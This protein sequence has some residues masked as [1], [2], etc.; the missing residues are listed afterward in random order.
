MTAAAGAEPDR[1]EREPQI[2][3]HEQVRAGEANDLVVRLA[4]VA[5]GGGRG[6]IAFDLAADEESVELA[7]RLHAPGFE[8][9][10]DPVAPMTVHRARDPQT[11]RVRF[12]LTARDPGEQPVRREVSAEFWLGN[13]LIGAVTHSTFVV[14]PDQEGGPADGRTVTRGF[15]LPREKREDADLIVYIVADE[16]GGEARY[17]VQVR[18]EIP[19]HEVGLLPC[20]RLDLPQKD[21]G[22]YLRS[23]LEETIGEYP[24]PGALS[25]AKFTDALAQWDRD[26]LDRLGDLGKKL[27]GFL[28]QRF[29]D[30]YF[31]LYRADAAPASI[32][33]HSDEMLFPWELV[34][35]TDVAGGRF[36][37]LPP[38]GVNHVLGRWGTALPMRPSPQRLGVDKFVVL[39]PAY[40]PPDDLPWTVAE[41]KALTKLLPGAEVFRPS[42]VQRIRGDLL[43]R[44]D[45]RLLHFS[46][47]GVFDPDNADLSELLLEDLKG[48]DALAI[49][50]TRL[51]AEGSPIVYLNA[52]SVGAAG[53]TVGRAGGFAAAC[54]EGGFSGV[55]APY[56]PVNDERAAKFAVALYRKLL[57]G[58][59]IG[60]ALRELRAE[61]PDDTTVRAF[62]Y[63]GDPWARLDLSALVA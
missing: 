53:V 61:R 30:K 52:C 10:P 42:T 50:R 9:A 14:R 16:D 23:A 15:T 32:L 35:P 24:D 11:E 58:R 51:G 29:R 19:G 3:F 39:N 62:A 43:K 17:H 37:E 6:R 45:V 44:G 4:D 54:L 38:L 13:A 56:W 20:G 34:I 59:A 2:D 49:A 60:E 55:I 21:L 63:F 1:I 47:H 27:W 12:T 41:T 40:P 36:E 5:A 46:G 18:S 8:V 28:P 26:F 48:L 57:A 33:V 22:A 7:V 31:E 25:A